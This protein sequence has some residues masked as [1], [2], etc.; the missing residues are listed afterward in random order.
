MP[1]HMMDSSLFVIKVIMYTSE[2]ARHA[3]GRYGQLVG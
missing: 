2:A 3:E 1:T